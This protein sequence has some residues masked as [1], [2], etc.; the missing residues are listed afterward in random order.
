MLKK[1]KVG[2]KIEQV[3]VQVYKP[4]I[5]GGEVISFI[6]EDLYPVFRVFVEGIGWVYWQDEFSDIMDLPRP[7][8]CY[9]VILYTGVS[10]DYNAPFYLKAM[11]VNDKAN[12]MIIK[13]LDKIRRSNPEKNLTDFDFE[14]T[15]QIMN[16]QF[17]YVTGID[18]EGEC[19]WK[20]NPEYK[21]LISEFNNKFDTMLEASLAKHVSKDEIVQA[22][23]NPSVQQNSKFSNNQ[24]SN[25]R[26]ARKNLPESSGE[27]V[28]N[29]DISTLMDE[30][31]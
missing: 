18:L 5:N 31:D 16:N 30:L 19:L 17:A 10:G 15:I 6:S 26:P 11:L 27:V 14:P 2:T 9:P 21:K 24:I 13:R 29:A 22:L 8:Y 1:V 23:N 12:E 4:D 7:R 3:G 25:N 20:T 28:T